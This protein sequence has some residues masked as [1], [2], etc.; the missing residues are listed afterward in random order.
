M[1]DQHERVAAPKLE[2]GIREPQAR[3][4][5]RHGLL[6]DPREP[7]RE[8]VGERARGTDAGADD[9]L[10]RTQ[11]VDRAQH[12]ARLDA[13][14]RDVDEV[15]LV[16]ERLVEGA[17]GVV[18]R[19]LEA[20]TEAHRRRRPRAQRV[21]QLA[22][23]LGETGIP[24][25]F[26]GAD[27]RRVARAELLTD[28]RRRQE[29]SLLAVLDEEAPDPALRRAQLARDDTLVDGSAHDNDSFIP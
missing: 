21:D 20:A 4:R 16:R 22:A 10:R 12:V 7:Q 23:E 27:D 17:R 11:D 28:L 5:H 19:R 13:M 6:L 25:P 9:A 26:D 15:D 18:A 14:P 2:Q 8:I 1:R 3:R 24:E 29:R